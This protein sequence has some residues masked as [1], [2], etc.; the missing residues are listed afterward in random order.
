MTMMDCT[1]V[2]IPM[3]WVHLMLLSFCTYTAPEGVAKTA[4]FS[5]ENS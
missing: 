3:G 2:Y 4:D 1:N 5:E